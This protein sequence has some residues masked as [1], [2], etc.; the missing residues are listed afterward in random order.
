MKIYRHR[1]NHSD[2]LREISA[3]YGVEIDI[4]SIGRDLILE[5][6][7]FVTGELFSEWLKSWN[8]QSLILNVKEDA[9]EERIL[10]LLEE[11]AVKD[12]FFLDQSFPSMQRL[13]S[14]GNQNFAARV[15]DLEDITTALSSGANWVWLDSFSGEWEYLLDTVDLITSNGQKTC[16]VSPELQRL[17]SELELIRLKNILVSE[18]L[19]IDAVCTKKYADWQS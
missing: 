14:Q 11:F 3:E 6:D 9:L 1:I 8:G 4:R 17:D 19:K 7:P 13:R 10:Q 2:V 16:L 5:H 15:S 18:G 12:Y